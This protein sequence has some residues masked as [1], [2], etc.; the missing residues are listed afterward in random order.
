MEAK[1]EI[2]EAASKDLEKI[3]PFICHLEETSFPFD[4]FKEIYLENIGNPDYIYLVAVDDSDE[5]VGFLS[6]HGQQL[7]QHAGLA[8]EIHEMYVARNQRGSGVGKALINE[9]SVRIAKAGYK[10]LEMSARLTQTDAKKFFSKMGFSATH[11]KLV[12]GP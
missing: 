10:S 3:F 11:V 6:C 5:A 2:R 8:Y 9:L 7:L 4:R 1:V 12:K